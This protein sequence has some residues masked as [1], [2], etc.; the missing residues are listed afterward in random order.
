MDTA[1]ETLAGYLT[2]NPDDYTVRGGVITSPGK[3]EGEPLYVPYYYGIGLE[4]F[5]DESGTLKDGTA[6]DAFYISED[7]EKACAQFFDGNTTR[8]YDTVILYYSDS[9]SVSAQIA[10]RAQ[11]MLWA[12]DERCQEGAE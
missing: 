9:G 6:W 1:R 11:F 5:A 10:T 4:G 12:K 7:E 2:T 3:F 8:E